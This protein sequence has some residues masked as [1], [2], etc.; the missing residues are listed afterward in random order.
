MDRRRQRLDEGRVEVTNVIRDQVQPIGTDDELVGHTAL[1]VATTKELQV[2]AQV[3]GA[4]DAWLALPA[5]QG[6]L[7]DDAVTDRYRRDALTELLDNAG[8][9]VTRHVGDRDEWVTAVEGVRIRPAHPNEGAAHPD[10]ARRGRGNRL[11]AQFHGLD[12]R[13]DDAAVDGH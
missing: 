13:H 5:G 8:R 10:L 3:L 7:N 2:L 11:L 9:L 4:A 1:G 12:G 6:W